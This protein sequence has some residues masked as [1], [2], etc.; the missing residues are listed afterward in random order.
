VQEHAPNSTDAPVPEFLDYKGVNRLFGIRRRLLWRL[1]AE[2]H[3][4]GI[5]I[6]QYG[7]T[8]G[9]RLFDCDSIR[10]FLNANADR[11]PVEQPPDASLQK[12]I[13]WIT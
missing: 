8:R 4:R 7:K 12:D 5:S 10:R 13:N 1:L 6:R 11:E 2:G 9:K 3:I